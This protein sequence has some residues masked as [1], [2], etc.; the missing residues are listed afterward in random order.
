MKSRVGG[1]KE[2][3]DG[4]KDKDLWRERVGIEP[5][6]VVNASHSVLKTGKCTSY[7]SAPV[8]CSDKSKV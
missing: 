5:T 1:L 3:G 2:A 7:S 6:G 8:K 4:L